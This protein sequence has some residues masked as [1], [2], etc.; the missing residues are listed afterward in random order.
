MVDRMTM[1][2]GEPNMCAGKPVCLFVRLQFCV[3]HH[4][5]TAVMGDKWFHVNL[6][7]RNLGI[8]A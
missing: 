6:G 2:F 4:V 5:N 1:L 8:S 3:I 7:K